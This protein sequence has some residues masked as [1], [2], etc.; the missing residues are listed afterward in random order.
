MRVHPDSRELGY[1]VRPPGRV[2]ILIN[3]GQYDYLYRNDGGHFVDVTTESGIGKNPYYGLS[4]T[5]WD[6]NDDGWPDLYVANDYMGPDHLFQ[7]LGVDSSGTVR[8]VDVA[9]QALPYTPWFSMGSDYSDIN[10]DGK[11]DLMASDMAGSNHYR[12]KVSMGSMS[13]PNSDAWF[14][15]FP[16]PPQYMRNVLYLN[17]GTERFMEVAYLNGLAATD[18]TWTVKFGDLDNDGFEDVYFTNGMSRDFVNGDLKDRFRNLAGNNKKIFEEEGLMVYWEDEE[19]YRLR[20]LVYKNLGGLKFK[21]VSSDWSLDHFGVS[22]G[23]ALGDLDGDG[24]LDMVMNGFNEPA[25]VYRNDVSNSSNAIR[26]ILIGER[27]N[28]QGLGARI[29]MEYDKKSKKMFRYSSSSRG[30]MSS[31]ESIVHFGLGKSNRADK[32][33]IHWPS[34]AVQTLRDIP[35]GYLYT[36]SEKETEVST[37]NQ[38]DV[39][40]KIP[41]KLKSTN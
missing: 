14:L 24:D 37:K 40:F 18:W 31:S 8:F 19:P 6:Y 26:I 41:K 34:G 13:G 9:D 28:S 22:T 4:S 16:N 10:N 7:N 35:A 15:N 27:T 1:F 30:F 32:I 33:T 38:E 36:V 20:N 29:E 23:S 25:R 12:D 3:A 17:T 5:W 21:D 11:M 39:M 2:P